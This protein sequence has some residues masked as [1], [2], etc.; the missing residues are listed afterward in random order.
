MYQN[1]N[2]VTG[3]SIPEV[4]AS[5]RFAAS[6]L[7]RVR[8]PELLRCRYWTGSSQPAYELPVAKA[9]TYRVVLYCAESYFTA[10]AARR[11]GIMV[12]DTLA[13]TLFAHNIFVQLEGQLVESNIDLVAEIGTNTAWTTS[14]VVTVSDGVLNLG[15]AR[16][17][18]LAG[19]ACCSTLM[20]MQRH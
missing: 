1:P 18:L 19:A 8:C 14:H 4:Y 10:T 12:C 5:E 2:V 7:A 13:L 20:T 11:F 16:F 17:V 15:F 3:T 6:C 9:G